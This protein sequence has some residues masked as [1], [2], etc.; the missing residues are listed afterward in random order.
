MQAGA[1]PADDHG[2]ESGFVVRRWRRYGADRLY[3]TGE[4]GV[5]VGSIDLQ[6]GAVTVE[7]PAAEQAVRRAAQAY[8]RADLPELQ[9]PRSDD[10]GGLLGSEASADGA[11][12]GSASVG[13]RVDALAAEGI[14][15]AE[16]WHVLR[17]VP[18]GRQGSVVELLVGPGGIFTLSRLAAG[19]ARLAG[20]SF[21]VEGRPSSAAW[22]ARL[23]AA[24][25]Q[26]LLRT[27][28][29]SALSVR[30]VLVVEGAL[31][32][33]EPVEDVLASAE[34]VLVVAAADVPE[35]FRVFAGRLE[36]ARADAIAG[37]ARHRATWG[38]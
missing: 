19:R 8:L 4:T 35:V 24:R 13:G 11:G 20:R 29:G 10:S 15:A 30:G 6:S 25:V 38:R 27:A 28:V 3:V 26:A 37:M 5:P 21:T 17:D 12:A 34:D 32:V 9:L 16:G 23:E 31:A 22:L 18:V 33:V 36:Q 2:V 14:L 7:A 1:R